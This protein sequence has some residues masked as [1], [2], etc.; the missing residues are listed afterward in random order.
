MFLIGIAATLL[1]GCIG[2]QG[3]SVN[4]EVAPAEL[5]AGLAF[6][7]TRDSFFRHCEA[8]NRRGEMVEGQSAFVRLDLGDSTVA[9][10]TVLEF[11]PNFD[12]L[13]RIVALPGRIYSLSW[14]PWNSELDGVQI[15][16]PAV[17]YLEAELGGNPFELL[18]DA[19]L[20]TYVK[21]DGQRRVYLRPD[22]AILQF[23]EFAIDAPQ[24]C[25]GCEN[26]D[27]LTLPD[28]N[29]IFSRQMHVK[30]PS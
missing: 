4:Q 19:P 3:S 28:V 13:N 24:P 16:G 21:R 26:E 17:A 12:S 11:Y 7:M 25:R 30:P 1:T 18:A 10:N 9:L 15:L 2:D 6:G 5:L 29:P 20:P 23:V 27:L 8:A 22:P 14:A